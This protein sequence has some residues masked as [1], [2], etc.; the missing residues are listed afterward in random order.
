M[1]LYR[2]LANYAPYVSAYLQKFGGDRVLT[3]VFEEFVKDI[4]A[5]FG[6]VCDF[7]EIDS[8]YEPD[9]EVHNA[10]KTLRSMTLRRLPTSPMARSLRSVVPRP[11]RDKAKETLVRL[12]T[13][14]ER[15]APMRPDLRHQ[16]EQEFAE[17]ITQLSDLLGRDLS[18]VWKQKGAKGV[19]VLP[20]D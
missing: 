7:L 15:R 4:P 18:K 20:A 17:S 19:E 5:M 9:F 8:G 2:D 12:N 1:L 3:L 14:I 10:N 16:L 13:K 6:Q 11:L